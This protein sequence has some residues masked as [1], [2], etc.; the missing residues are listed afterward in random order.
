M[1]H[2]S[3]V[4]A[5][6]ELTAPLLILLLVVSAPK[7]PGIL[8]MDYKIFLIANHALQA[9]YVVLKVCVI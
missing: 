2:M 6:L 5:H 8:T 1:E 9:V 7:V 3:Q 4:F